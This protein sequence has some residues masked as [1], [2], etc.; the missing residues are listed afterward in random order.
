M[1]PGKQG[2]SPDAGFCEFGWCYYHSQTAATG[3]SVRL[4]AA[5]LQSIE[6]LLEI[7]RQAQEK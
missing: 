2:S 7:N 5:G 4:A 6:Y 3:A 1:L